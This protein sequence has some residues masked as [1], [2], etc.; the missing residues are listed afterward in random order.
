[1]LSDDHVGGLLGFSMKERGKKTLALVPL[2]L[3]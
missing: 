2:N 1:M 3:D